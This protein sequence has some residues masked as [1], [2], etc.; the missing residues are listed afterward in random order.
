MTKTDLI[1]PTQLPNT[2][3]NS[4]YLCMKN[5]ARQLHNAHHMRYMNRPVVTAEY[6]R[7]EH[8]R[9]EREII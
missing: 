6:K 3:H 5:E 8:C 2:L 7:L 9:K 1:I 4:S